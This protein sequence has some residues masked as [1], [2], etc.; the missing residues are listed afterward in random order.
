M[1]KVFNFI[2][3]SL[4]TLFSGYVFSKTPISMS[5]NTTVNNCADYNIVR[6][7]QNIFESSSNFLY[8]SEYLECSLLIKGFSEIKSEEVASVLSSIFKNFKIVSI[9][10]SKAQKL[11]DKDTF[12]SVGGALLIEKKQITLS[13]KEHNFLLSLKGKIDDKYLVWIV[14]EILVGTYRSY[15]PA[16]LTIDGDKVTASP[17]YESGY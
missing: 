7:S 10:S 13:D 14:D 6:K 16:L 15:Y 12:S 3:A 1:F 2:L 11:S 4:A 5:D 9:P 8:A 17:F